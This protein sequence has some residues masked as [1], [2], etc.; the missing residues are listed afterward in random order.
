MMMMT[1]LLGFHLQVHGHLFVF[2]NK[3][4]DR[5]KLLYW[6]PKVASSGFVDLVLQFK[7]CQLFTVVEL[8]L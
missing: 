1:I 6:A 4:S 8:F 7:A 5:T 2:I 3:R